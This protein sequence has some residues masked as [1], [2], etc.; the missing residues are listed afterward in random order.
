[1]T[2]KRYGSTATDYSSISIELP[3]PN[4]MLRIKGA[5]AAI[6]DDET[7]YPLT[8]KEYIP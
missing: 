6:E 8:F 4:Y 2:F 3:N 1:M 7:I 5:T